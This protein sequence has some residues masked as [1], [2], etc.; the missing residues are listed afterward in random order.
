MNLVASARSMPRSVVCGLWSVVRRSR[1]ASR[2]PLSVVSCQL[3]ASSGFT[4]LESHHRFH[5][6]WVNVWHYFFLFSDE[7]K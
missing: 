5:D 7:F 3:S 1:S 2:R 6:S 4:L